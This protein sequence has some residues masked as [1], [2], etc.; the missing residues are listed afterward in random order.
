MSRT[1]SQTPRSV[2]SRASSANSRTGRT[3]S[4]SRGSEVAFG[5]ATPT[6]KKWESHSFETPSPHRRVQMHI[7]TIDEISALDSFTVGGPSGSVR[8]DKY[9]PSTSTKSYGGSIVH[10]V[11]TPFSL[12]EP[13]VVSVESGLLEVRKT[14]SPKEGQLPETIASIPLDMI[15]K[16]EMT[17]GGVAISGRGNMELL[18]TVHNQH[19]QTVLYKVLHAKTKGTIPSTRG[20]EAEAK[21]EIVEAEPIISSASIPLVRDVGVR[22]RLKTIDSQAQQPAKRG[23]TSTESSKLRPTSSHHN[24]APNGADASAGTTDRNQRREILYAQLR[25]IRQREAARGAVSS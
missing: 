24:G 6:P 10:R 21:K 9:S 13:V 18:L 3:R 25:E 8:L 17:S 4:H 16:V 7:V 5:R 12:Q 19:K 2:A 22:A 11:T 14:I 23:D 20:E 1:P 15:A